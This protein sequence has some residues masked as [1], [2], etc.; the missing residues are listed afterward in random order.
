MKKIA[1]LQSNYIP[2][3]RYF[4]MIAAV[5]KFILY[6]GMLYTGRDCHNRNKVNTPPQSYINSPLPNQDRWTRYLSIAR[7]DRFNPQILNKYT[8]APC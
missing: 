3:K 2:W 8:I 7:D 5:D 4:D 6:N 1:I